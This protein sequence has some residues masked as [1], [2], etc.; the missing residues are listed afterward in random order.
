M[1]DEDE[2]FRFSYYCTVCKERSE[3]FETPEEAHDARDQHQE[4]K[5]SD[6]HA[7][8]LIQQYPLWEIE[9]GLVR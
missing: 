9:E 4:E 5:H 2:E 1:T 8:V 7:V 6:E 3:W